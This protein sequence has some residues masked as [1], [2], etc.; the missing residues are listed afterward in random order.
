MRAS[1]SAACI[2]L[3]ACSNALVPSHRC[4][5]ARVAR[6][7]ADVDAE[8]PPTADDATPPAADE[9]ASAADETASVDAEEAPQASA[10]IATTASWRLALNVGRESGTWM[11]DDWAA[12][13]ARLLLP[14][15][16]EFTADQY[17]GEPEPLVGR[18]CFRVRPL[19]EST[20][21]GAG[22][23]VNVKV[24]GGAW[25]VAPP[26]PGERPARLRFWLEFPEA[27]AR[28]DVEL[29]AGRVFFNAPVWQRPELDAGAD[30]LADAEALLKTRQAALD[31]HFEEHGDDLTPFGAP[32]RFRK[33][34][35]LVDARDVALRR[36]KFVKRLMPD[37]AVVPGPWPGVAADSALNVGAG[38]LVVKRRGRIGVG[39]EYHILGKF[40]CAPLG[41][42]AGA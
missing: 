25:S 13:G 24:K 37:G 12:S 22:G 31:A 15:S 10:P 29:P 20:F 32:L 21:V 23:T 40:E 41:D 33:R 42:G 38:G 11:P 2:T 5:L 6:R 16:C 3:L 17:L 1:S 36:V 18:T 27:C 39:V 4:T 9:T 26:K 35:D 8:A 30:T 19:G 7:A 14:V 28:N 34:V